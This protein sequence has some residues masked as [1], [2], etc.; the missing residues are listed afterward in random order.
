MSKL[1]LF[2]SALLMFTSCV[3]Q[4]TLHSD[5]SSKARQDSIIEKYLKQGAWKYHYFSKEWNT[6]I[7]EGLRQDSTIAYLWQ[8]KAMPFFKRRKYEVGLQ[9]LD[10]A[11]KY[12]KFWLDY[13]GYIKCIFAK[14][15]KEALAD[16]QECK[17]R[18]DNGRIMDHSYDFYM[19][20]CYLQLNNFQVA[21]FILKA[22]IDKT[23]KEKGKDWVHYLD[24]FYLGIIYYELADYDKAIVAFD[25]SL[26]KYPN[27]SD[28]KYFK[29]KCIALKGDY[30]KGTDLIKEAKKDFEKG[31]TIN[32]DNVLYE[33]YPYQVNW[34]MVQ[35]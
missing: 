3:G 19:A 12:D 29:G 27:F 1:F 20:L 33:P 16:F 22:D 35:L 8:Q 2:I 28:A 18:N 26:F 11:V 23:E 32:E 4:V 6:Y 24:L 9:Y 13:R 21:L 25:R 7:D 15:Y 17:K 10:Q 34:K 31:Y 5:P 14:T 30:D